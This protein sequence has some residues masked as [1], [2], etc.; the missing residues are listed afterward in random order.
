MRNAISED[1]PIELFTVHPFDQ[2]NQCTDVNLDDLH[3]NFEYLVK[4]FN[5]RFF[6]IEYSS[7]SIKN[8]S[9]CSN[10]N[11]SPSKK[12]VYINKNYNDSLNKQKINRKDNN[13]NSSPKKLIK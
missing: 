1:S 5:Q 2:F 4:E 13:N 6:N 7:K 9:Y 3:I 8:K 11:D 12:D 10:N